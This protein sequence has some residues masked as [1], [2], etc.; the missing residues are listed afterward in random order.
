MAEH[1]AAASTTEI[2]SFGSSTVLTYTQY[3]LL[4]S[5]TISALQKNGTWYYQF[6]K[7]G[8]TLLVRTTAFSDSVGNKF[9]SPVSLKESGDYFTTSIWLTGNPSTSGTKTQM[10]VV[11]S[12]T[13]K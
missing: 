8:N 12:M 6:T 2:T 1:S 5:G 9:E 10:K 13:T 3:D 11:F 7:N 4:R